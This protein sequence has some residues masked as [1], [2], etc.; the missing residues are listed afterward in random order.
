MVKK[1]LK[2]TLVLCVITFIAGLMLGAVEY[3]TREPIAQAKIEAKNKAYKEV[4]EEAD[5]FKGNEELDNALNNKTQILKKIGYSHIS[6]DEGVGA[7]KGE[8]LIGYVFSV[9]TKEGYGGEITLAVGVRMDGT[10]TGYE[11]LAIDETPGLGMNAGEKS[12]K[13]QFENKKIP[14][15]E[16]TKT[17][18]AKE[19]EVDAIS[20]ATITTKAVTG[21]VNGVGAFVTNSDTGLIIV[22]EGADNE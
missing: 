13:S 21:A 22:K 18:A 1:I 2:D 3:I 16:W 9:T 4:F 15:I 14:G 12:F 5:E 8:E 10:L 17:G 11:I 20:G 6:I 19:N 7:Y